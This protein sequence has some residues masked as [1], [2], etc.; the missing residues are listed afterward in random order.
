MEGNIV[1]EG[2]ENFSFIDMPQEELEL[3]EHFNRFIEQ[4]RQNE[5]QL[6]AKQKQQ[7]STDQG[8]P[9]VAQK[10]NSS[11]NVYTKNFDNSKR[12]INI[13]GK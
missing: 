10:K 13:H 6:Q 11:Q 7:S 8:P 3:R 2:L 9:T 1:I 5:I 4:M 12:D